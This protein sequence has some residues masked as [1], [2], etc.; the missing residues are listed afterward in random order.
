M[1][2][3]LQLSLET[4]LY[5]ISEEKLGEVSSYLKIEDIEGK[6]RIFIIRKIRQ[7]VEKALA[8]LEGR[9]ADSQ[10]I[11]QY[12]GDVLAFVTGKPPPLED[13]VDE[14]RDGDCTDDEESISEA[15]REYEAMQTEFMEMLS[16]QEKKLQKAKARFEVLTTGKKFTQPTNEVLTSNHLFR[17]KDFK[18][19]GTISNEKTRVSYTSLNKQIE[20]GIEKRYSNREIIDAV[21]NAVSPSL[22]L[23]SYLESIKTLSLAELRQV[24][25]SHYCEK[26]A[27]EAYQELAN[28]VQEASES[29]LQF[30]M[31]ALKLRQHI[32][33]ASE[34][35]GSKIKYDNDLVQSVFL[36]TVET[37]L[38]DDTIRTRMRPFLQANKVSDETL[39]REINV[40]MSS[41]NERQNKFG[42]RK[43]ATK[44]SQA[45]IAATAVPELMQPTAAESKKEKSNKLI[46]TL[47]ALRADVDVLKDAMVNN[48]P[49]KPIDNPDRKPARSS[50]CEACISQ[51]NPQCDHCFI[52]GSNEHFARGCRKR[53]QK[54]GN[55]GRLHLRDVV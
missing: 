46:A 7:E 29:P 35:K 22:H 38:M 24:L 51:G 6:S 17:I 50:A 37:G 36:N 2:E 15:K 30:L 42:A 1:A 13:S 16:L 4:E 34:E 55:R 11:V 3:E 18:I 19:Q 47:E 28:L 10:D 27:S 48:K 45:T 32:L 33:L 25:R 49:V 5:K 31:R 53:K 8:V 52:C 54:Q 23:R 12:L 9:E 41:E 40:A 39:I 14:D 21:I 43:R 44:T 20:S 26:T